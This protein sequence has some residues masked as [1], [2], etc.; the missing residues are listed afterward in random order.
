MSVNIPIALQ[1]TTY[2]YKASALYLGVEIN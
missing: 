2:L 1:L